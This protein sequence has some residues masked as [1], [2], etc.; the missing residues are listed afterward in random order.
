MKERRELAE[1]MIEAIGLDATR[2]LVRLYGG[3]RIKVPSGKGKPGSF[4][5][6]LDDNLGLEAA[7]RFRATFGGEDI[8][9]P[10]LYAQLIAFRNRLI[11]EDYSAGLPMLNLVMKHQLTERQIRSIINRPLADVEFTLPVVDDRQ[12]GLF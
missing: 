4:S 5:A 1:A 6:W 7:R 10:K 8:A 2:T 9:V 3:K 11:V 12:M